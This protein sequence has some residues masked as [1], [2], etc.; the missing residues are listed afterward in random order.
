MRPLSRRGGKS[1]EQ[2]TRLLLAVV[3]ELYASAMQGTS[4]IWHKIYEQGSLLLESE[5]GGFIS[6]DKVNQAADIASLIGFD[7]EKA[8]RAYREFGVELDLLFMGTLAMGAGSTFLGTEKIGFRALQRSPFYG[9]LSAP[10]GLRFVCGGILENDELHHSALYFWRR[11]DRPDFDQTSTA[12]LTAFLP[13]VRQ[14][15]EV[16]RRIRGPQLDGLPAGSLTLANFQS[17][18]HGILVLDENGKVLFVNAEGERIARSG[19]GVSIRNGFLAVDDSQVTAAIE[20]VMSLAIGIARDG[21]FAQVRPVRIPRLSGRHS[22][23]F[24]IIPVTDGVQRAVLPP[25]AAFIVA[26]TD[27]AAVD[28]MS[29]QRLLGYGL[30]GA[31][32]RLCEALIRTGSL[33]HAA[34]ALHI[35]RSTARS[36]LKNIFVKLGVTSQVQ[37]VTRL[38]T[39]LP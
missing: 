12:T 7:Q 36:H 22:Y 5:A 4:E 3:Q 25:A 39:T 1:D 13:H 10:L 32:A 37:L 8:L 23:E 18:R 2:R 29:R 17:S 38:A 26:I 28:G 9:I 20:R 16:Q 35:T 6:T 27:S 11:A 24:L 31:E 14:A 33:P 21:T 15:L 34:D 30:T 19:D